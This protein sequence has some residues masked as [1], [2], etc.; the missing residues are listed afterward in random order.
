MLVPITEENAGRGFD[1][2]LTKI[3]PAPKETQTRKTIKIMAE[4]CQ[5]NFFCTSKSTSLRK[6]KKKNRNEKMHENAWGCI[7]GS[8]QVLHHTGDLQQ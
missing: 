2:F 4:S 8:V 1:A 3:P 5:H 6:E 7:I